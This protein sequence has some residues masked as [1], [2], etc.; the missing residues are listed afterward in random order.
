MNVPPSADPEDVA[1]AKKFDVTVQVF[2][3]TTLI[4]KGRSSWRRIS[5]SEAKAAFVA[6]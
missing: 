3:S 5:E 2:R 6:E 4:M 1:L